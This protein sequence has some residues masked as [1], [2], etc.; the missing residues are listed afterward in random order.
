MNDF[1]S[2]L[3]TA[4]HDRVAEVHPDLD[5]LVA[6]STRAGVR[7]RLRR[8]VGVSVAA[9]AGVAAVAAGA[10]MIAG[11]T[12]GQPAGGGVGFAAEPSPTR[13]AAPT[14]S[15]PPTQQ[16]A[17]ESAPFRVTASGW[18]CTEPADEKFDCTKGADTVHVV[19]RDASSHADYAAGTPDKSADWVSKVHHGV[20]VT[21]D[22][23]GARQVGQSIRWAKVS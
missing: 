7:I 11:G 17:P 6:A 13:T 21:V 19:W 16:I 14:P 4:L 20:F 3:G 2:R 12:N 10:A 1:D 5:R 18:T 23:P 9:A 8:R 15:T 22:G